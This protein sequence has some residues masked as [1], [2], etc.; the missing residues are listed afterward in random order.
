MRLRAPQ[1]LEFLTLLVLSQ[2]RQ[3]MIVFLIC[4]LAVLVIDYIRAHPGHIFPPHRALVPVE[5]EPLILTTAAERRSSVQRSGRITK[6]LV[7]SETI[8]LMEL[9]HTEWFR[10]SGSDAIIRPAPALT[11]KIQEEGL[12]APLRLLPNGKSTQSPLIMQSN[13]SLTYGLSQLKH[14]SIT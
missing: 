4:H 2:S 3:A 6:T 5:S 11:R 1:R 9:S 8:W 10:P 13:I 14:S 12:R 7:P